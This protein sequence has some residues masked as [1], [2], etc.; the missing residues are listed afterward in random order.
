MLERKGGRDV[1]QCGVQPLLSPFDE[2]NPS[3]QTTADEHPELT[4]STDRFRA[5]LRLVWC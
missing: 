4:S 3:W 5:L 1:A 2:E